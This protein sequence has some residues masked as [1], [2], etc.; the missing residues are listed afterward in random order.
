[1]YMYNTC[2]LIIHVRLLESIDFGCFHGEIGHPLL[3]SVHP[4]NR[5][6]DFRQ[7]SLV[8]LTGGLRGRRGWAR[9]G[10]PVVR[11]LLVALQVGS[12]GGG[13]A[14]QRGHES[15][16]VAVGIDIEARHVP[17]E[18]PDQLLPHH[19]WWRRQAQV[20][21]WPWTCV[22]TYVH[23]CCTLLNIVYL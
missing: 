17:L 15:A 4:Q 7:G 5:R 21:T 19:N 11:G 9:A 2:T 20:Y 13:C 8:L 16:N 23:V 22:F 6:T 18:G 3:H 14:D 1:M 10:S 12:D